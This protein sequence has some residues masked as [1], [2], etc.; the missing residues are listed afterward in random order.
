MQSIFQIGKNYLLVDTSYLPNF[1][2]GIEYDLVLTQKDCQREKLIAV[3]NLCGD[4][5]QLTFMLKRCLPTLEKWKVDIY[6]K[7]TQNLLYSLYVQ[8]YPI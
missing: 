6:E 4:K 7:N 2:E 8:V 5:I 1:L 3:A